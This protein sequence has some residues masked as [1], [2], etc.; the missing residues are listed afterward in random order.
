MKS[1]PLL[2][3]RSRQGNASQGGTAAR[4]RC[5]VDQRYTIAIPRKDSSKRCAN[6]KRSTAVD[7]A[8]RSRQPQRCRQRR[9]AARFT[10]AHHS[11]APWT[12]RTG[13]PRYC[14]GK[15]AVEVQACKAAAANLSLC[16][17]S[18]QESDAKC[19]APLTLTVSY[20]KAGMANG[21]F[22]AVDSQGQSEHHGPL[23]KHR[24]QN[25]ECRE[26]S[27]AG[28][29]SRAEK[30]NAPTAGD[31]G[32]RCDRRNVSSIHQNEVSPERELCR[33][34]STT[35]IANCCCSQPSGAEGGLLRQETVARALSGF[36]AVAS[37]QTLFKATRFR[38]ELLRVTTPQYK[39]VADQA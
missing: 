17:R 38:D 18:R 1:K 2:L 27:H 24:R 28:V 10:T 4:E 15:V 39:S 30:A 25:K 13:R 7:A 20:D 3:R 12:S 22:P 26:H 33:G 34:R 36:R 14:G 6:T 32:A 29:R 11:S 35:G 8:S 37:S 9:T 16:R 19:L 23:S 5:R 31:A 21:S